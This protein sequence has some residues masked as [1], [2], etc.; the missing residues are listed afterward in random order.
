ML[1]YKNKLFV[2]L[3]RARTYYGDLQPDKGMLLVINMEND[4]VEKSIEIDFASRAPQIYKN[5]LY[6]LAMGNYS[7]PIGKIYRIDLSSYGLDKDFTVSSLTKEDNSTDYIKNF[8]ITPEGALVFVANAGWGKPYNVYGITNVELYDDDD[9]S[10]LISQPIYSS[11]GYISDMDF[12]CGN[13]VL[14]D[15]GSSPGLVFIPMGEG[16]TFK[17]SDTDL[18]YPPYKIGSDYNY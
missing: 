16:D 11:T 7:A 14:T 2:T 5:Y 15:R 10:G 8:I 12:Y 1:I 3:D 13:I 17:I 4:T 9:K 6:F 18:G